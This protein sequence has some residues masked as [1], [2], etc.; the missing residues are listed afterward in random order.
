MRPNFGEIQDIVTEFL[1]L[2]GGHGL[3]IDPVRK[4]SLEQ[5]C[6]E[7]H[8]VDFPCWEFSGLDV[9]EHEFGSIVWVFSGE[10]GC[11]FSVKSL[12]KLNRL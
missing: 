1:S 12:G 4:F 9:V 8:N 10:A 5:K 7:T 3:L 11:R 6:A 2:F